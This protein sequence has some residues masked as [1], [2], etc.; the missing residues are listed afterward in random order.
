MR[1]TP[2]WKS[3]I[4]PTIAPGLRVTTWRMPTRSGGPSA[5]VFRKAAAAPVRRLFLRSFS[6]F[7]F[8]EGESPVAE[9]ETLPGDASR[10]DLTDDGCRPG[11][12]D[13]CERSVITEGCGRASRPAVHGA[14]VHRAAV[15]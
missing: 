3:A 2:S 15:R 6:F 13:G 7:F 9:K 5:S 12:G 1:T 8:V 14:A 11:D 4:S 10:F